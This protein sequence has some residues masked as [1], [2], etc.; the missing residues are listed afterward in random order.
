MI[1]SVTLFAILNAKYAAIRHM[2]S[3]ERYTHC[4][5]HAY[6]LHLFS[7]VVLKQGCRH[8]SYAYRVPLTYIQDIDP[9]PGFVCHQ[10]ISVVAVPIL[11]SQYGKRAIFHVRS[12]RVP[13]SGLC[14]KLDPLW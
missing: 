11:H 7:Y 12:V 10:F 14:S 1:Y 4:T 2:L 6:V 13:G 9:M 3:T 8:K 5:R